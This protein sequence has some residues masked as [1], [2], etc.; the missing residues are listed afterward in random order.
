MYSAP[1]LPWKQAFPRKWLL[2]WAGMP[3]G[4]TGVQEVEWLLRYFAVATPDEWAA[5]Y[6][7][8]QVA[9]RRSRLRNSDEHAIASW[10]RLAEREAQKVQCRRGCGTRV[11]CGRAALSG[12]RRGDM[13]IVEQGDT[14]SQ[15][16][17]L[18]V[19]Q[20]ESVGL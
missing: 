14:T 8:A 1:R 11:H 20:D 19:E 6:G 2:D 3:E 15:G 7:S 17:T 5:N 13:A 16:E 12:E 18:M 9:Y 10:L 4:L